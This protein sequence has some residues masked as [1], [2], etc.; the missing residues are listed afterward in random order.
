M[1]VATCHGRV[2]S[3]KRKPRPGM[4][5]F[6]LALD[7]LPIRG[8]VAGGARQ[9]EFAVRTLSTRKRQHRLRMQPAPAHENQNRNR[10]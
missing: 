8:G 10:K 6:D 2:A 5:K 4:I 1:A 9:I 3:A 7:H